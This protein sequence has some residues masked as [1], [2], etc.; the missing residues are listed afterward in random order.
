MY[1]LIFVPK[2]KRKQNTWKNGLTMLY[3]MEWLLD[4]GASFMKQVKTMLITKEF[5]SGLV[6]D[7]RDCFMTV[8]R[9][10]EKELLNKK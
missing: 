3:S 7:E 1:K 6:F 10:D 5:C 2:Q 9:D 8:E 4:E